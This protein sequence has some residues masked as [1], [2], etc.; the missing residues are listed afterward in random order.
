MKN[1]IPISKSASKSA[2]ARIRNSLDALS[3]D[4][5]SYFTDKK[6]IRSRIM[7]DYSTGGCM[8]KICLFSNEKSGPPKRLIDLPL[9]R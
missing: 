9:K 2:L 8:L 5:D 7:R 1:A 3:L 6:R 4:F